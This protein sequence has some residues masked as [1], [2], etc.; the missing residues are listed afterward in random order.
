MIPDFAALTLFPALM[1]YAAFSDLFTMTISNKVSLIL[2]GAFVPFALMAH[3]PVADIALLHVL[4]GMGVLV[5]TMVFFARGWIGGG[6]P[7]W[8]PRPRSGSD[9]TTSRPTACRPR[10]SAP[11]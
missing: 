7:S 1:A 10:C 3:L 4:P 6:M 5:L 11:C 8:R 2:V 9:G